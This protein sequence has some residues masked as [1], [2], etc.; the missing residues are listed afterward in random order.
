MRGLLY[1]HN[2]SLSNLD[3]ITKFVHLVLLSFQLHL[4]FRTLAPTSASSSYVYV[5]LNWSS[6][7]T[8]WLSVLHPLCTRNRS[9]PDPA[10]PPANLLSAS[11][12]QLSLSTSYSAPKYIYT[13][14]IIIPGWRPKTELAWIHCRLAHGAHPRNHLVEIGC[15]SI[16]SDPN[17][18]GLPEETGNPRSQKCWLVPNP[19]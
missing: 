17:Q 11:L 2:L 7:P 15:W 6:I 12:A 3:Q 8:C 18:A 19:N 10:T 9:L 14:V 4:M 16:S 5:Y 1:W 13:V